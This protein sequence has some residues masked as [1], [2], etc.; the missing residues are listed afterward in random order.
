MSTECGCKRIG[1]R[2][3]P[4]KRIGVERTVNEIGV[5]FCR[6]IIPQAGAIYNSTTGNLTITNISNIT[7]Q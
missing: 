5:G 7:I 3:D 6:A 2:R 1:V 4:E